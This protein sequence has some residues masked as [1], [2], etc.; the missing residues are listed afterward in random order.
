MEQIGFWFLL[1]AMKLPMFLLFYILYKAINTEPEGQGG[2]DGDGGS[3]NPRPL[4]PRRGPH[5]GQ[6]IPPPP[7]VRRPVKA[8]P[9]KPAERLGV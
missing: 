6:P 5:G 4:Y 3:K 9:E 1:V 8:R 7:R 2:S